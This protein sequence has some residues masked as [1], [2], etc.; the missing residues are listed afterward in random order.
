MV[1]PVSP[2]SN[3]PQKTDP[4]HHHKPQS[5]K[6][7]HAASQEP[8]L[9]PPSQQPISWDKAGVWQKFLSG[10]GTQEVTEADVKGFIMGIENFFS[11]VILQQSD[12]AAK[13]SAEQMRKSFTGDE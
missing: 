6:K 7:G 10:R 13:R 9:E 8:S 1:S 5:N 2:S 11:K 4:H 12:R 3:E